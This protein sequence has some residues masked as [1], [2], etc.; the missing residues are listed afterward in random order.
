MKKMTNYACFLFVLLIG[1]VMSIPNLTFPLKAIYVDVGWDWNNPA[2]TIQAV[3]DSGYN[4]V[5]LPFYLSS[6]GPTDGLAAYMQLSVSQQ[7][8]VISYL[9]TKGCVLMLSAGGDTDLNWMNMNA[10]TYG[11]LIGT[12]AAQNGLDGLGNICVMN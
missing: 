6:T 7:Q 4:V 11:T 2:N 5:I 10:V 12:F 3:C 9:H 1:T 8:S